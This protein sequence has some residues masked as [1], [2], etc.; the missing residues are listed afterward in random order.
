MKRLATAADLNAEYSGEGMMV[1]TRAAGDAPTK[2]RNANTEN[3]G[4]ESGELSL[5]IR[6]R[7]VQ[8]IG[9]V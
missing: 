7:H 5:I 9:L 2:Q 6:R 4:E 3:T 1:S 8:Y